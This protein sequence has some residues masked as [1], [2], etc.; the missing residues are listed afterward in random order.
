[1]YLIADSS[2]N[3]QNNT[4][5]SNIIFEASQV[6]IRNPHGNNIV[7]FTVLTSTDA[8]NNPAGVYIDTAFIKNGAL[9]SAQ[10]GSLSV[11]KLSG[12]FAT[13][14]SVMTGTVSGTHI[15]AQTLTLSQV[16]FDSTSGNA[17]ITVS[18][19]GSSAILTIKSGGVVVDMIGANQIG[20][21]SSTGNLN[22][23][24]T[25]ASVN[26]SSFT[27]SSPFHYFQSTDKFGNPT[28]TTYMGGSSS[29]QIALNV[30]GTTIKETGTYV[31]TVMMQT[32]G[33]STNSSRSGMAINITESTSSS[34][35]NTN[36]A[37]S[38]FN[39]ATGEM[40]GNDGFHFAPKIRQEQVT[41]VAG[42]SYQIAGFF[43]GR[44]IGNAPDGS[45]PS[46]SSYINISRL[47]KV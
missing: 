43:Y 31:V 34:S 32:S 42:R 15:T 23:S 25:Q 4:S 18:G 22:Q 19:S 40:T 9:A 10:I 20:K 33:S 7:P 3:L 44:G 37:T 27:G 14:A 28:S 1:M 36:H 12:S 13:F 21:I 8:N 26:M 35:V 46:V 29:G 6:T 11:D 39:F 5:S 47:N 2:N 17:V 24:Y 16:N 45:S 30:L 38:H 41:F